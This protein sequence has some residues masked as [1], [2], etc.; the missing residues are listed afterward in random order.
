[1]AA[2]SAVRK[3]AEQLKQDG[4]TYFKKERFGA[5]IDAYT[6]AIALCPNVPVYWTNRALCHRKRN[7]WTRVEED[8]RRAIQLD[9]D[10]VKAILG[11]SSVVLWLF[12]FH[13]DKVHVVKGGVAHVTAIV[14]IMVV[15]GGEGRDSEAWQQ[16]GVACIGNHTN[17]LAGNL[18]MGLAREGRKWYWA[19]V[20]VRWSREVLTMR[21]EWG[22]RQG[23]GRHYGFQKGGR[24][25]NGFLAHYMLGLSLLQKKEF[26]EGVKELEKA[27]DLGRGAN[28]NGYMVE[29]IWQELAKAKYL[30]WEHESSRRSWELRTLKEA[31]VEALKEK[32]AFDAS[33]TDGFVDETVA[34][35]GKRLEAL[36]RVF[37]K[38]AEDDTPSE[39]PDYLCCKITLDIFRDPV[40]TPSGVTYERAVILDH[41]R[42]V[43]KFDPISRE[44]LDQSQLVPNL[45]IK[46]AVWAYLEK[47]GWAYRGRPPVKESNFSWCVLLQGCDDPGGLCHMNYLPFPA[48][49]FSRNIRRFRT[50]LPCHRPIVLRIPLNKG[51]EGWILVAATTNS[52]DRTIVRV[53]KKGKE[54]KKTT[55]IRGDSVTRPVMT[56]VLVFEGGPSFMAV[57]TSAF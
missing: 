20:G 33:N 25:S 3:Q 24:G 52:E 47:H 16:G 55:L 48:G 57:E 50:K 4:N 2:R 41:L 36:E 14:V 15:E 42:K 43:G 56:I 46:E 53:E 31:C 22:L 45:A 30:K 13:G 49:G 10:S 9:H 6:E 17:G 28:P 8:C 12:N 19:V 35:N 32:H 27:L 38:A 26:G 40:I 54:G 51:R 11:D 18:G 29:E 34:A 21:E 5:A 7:D 23:S 1:M 44:P 39:V 37:Q